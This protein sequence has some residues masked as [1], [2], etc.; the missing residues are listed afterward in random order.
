MTANAPEPTTAGIDAILQ[1]SFSFPRRHFLSAG[2]LN[3]PQAT[4]LPPAAN[5]PGGQSHA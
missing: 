5:V 2:D 4:S 1:R 3:A